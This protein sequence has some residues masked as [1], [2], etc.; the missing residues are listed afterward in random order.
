MEQMNRPVRNQHTKK[1]CVDAKA[2]YPLK[3]NALDAELVWESACKSEINLWTYWQGR[4]V[5]K[6][7][8]C[9]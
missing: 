5:R 7:K 2:T 1:L 4:S 9:L 3:G 8:L 6:P